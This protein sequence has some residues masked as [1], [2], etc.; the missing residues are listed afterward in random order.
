MDVNN[1]VK[2]IR[3]IDTLSNTLR[4]A[5][6][7]AAVGLLAACNPFG[8]PTVAERAPEQWPLVDRYCTECHN[9]AELA[10][11]FDFEKIGPNNVAQHAEKLEM[12]VRKLRS[13]AMPPP[14]E[15][16][17]DEAQLASFVSWLEDALDE[18]AA[19]NH[20]YQADRAASP[21]PQGIRERRSRPARARG[22]RHGVLAAGRRGQALR[23]HRERPASLAVVHRA[24]RRCGAADRRARRRSAR[25]AHG[26]P[27]LLRAAWAP[28]IARARLAARHARR[29]RR[30]RTCSRP[31][32]STKSTSPTCSATSG[33]TTRSSRTPSS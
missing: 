6:V 1:D 19:S 33:A 31:T 17:P 32:A 4:C 24:I 21:E 28:A 16:R 27:D 18:A 23:Q 12:A 7:L 20:G 11:G 13:H 5:G 14:K 9:G 26:R 30:R 25:C 15:P 2:R 8:E 22:R 29:L 10:G 3:S